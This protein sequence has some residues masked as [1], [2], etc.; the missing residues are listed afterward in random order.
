MKIEVKN[1]NLEQALRVLKKKLQ[2]EGTFRILKQK[3]HFEK[4]SEK[5][6]REKEESIKKFKKLRKLKARF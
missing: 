5:K 3:S 2:K 4:P 6:K 1:D